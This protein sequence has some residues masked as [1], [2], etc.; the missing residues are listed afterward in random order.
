MVNEDELIYISIKLDG[1]AEYEEGPA[2]NLTIRMTPARAM[3]VWLA[4]EDILEAEGHIWR[5]DSYDE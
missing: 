5:D 3:Q 4:L 2:E 1:Q